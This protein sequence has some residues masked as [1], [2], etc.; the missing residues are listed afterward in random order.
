MTDDSLSQR[1]A[2]LD[3]A[4]REHLEDVVE[5]LR[6]R[7][8]DN[9]RYQLTQKGLDDEPEGPDTL[10]EDIEQLVEAIELEG[11]DATTWDEAFEQYVTGVGYTIVNRL[12]ALRCMEVRDFIDEEVTVFKENGLTPAAETLVHEGVPLGG[13]GDS[14]SLPQRLATN[15]PRRSR[16]S[17]TAHRRTAWSTLTTTRS[18]NSVGCST[19]FPTRSGEQTTCLDGSTSTTTARWS[20]TCARAKKHPG[21]EDVG[22]ANQFYTPHWVVRMLTD[23]SLGNSISNTPAVAGRPETR[24][25]SVPMSERTDRLSPDESPTI[26][27]I[28]VPI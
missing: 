11:V 24:G 14:R 25:T 15:S 7:V 16:Y 23:N 18:R 20:T 5:E 1:K 10:D 19:R 8:E 9:V 27:P 22:P 13:R 4:E 12:A 3:K 6:E 2:Q 17:S 28:S 21:T 26:L